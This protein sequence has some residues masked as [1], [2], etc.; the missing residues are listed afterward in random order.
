MR[1]LIELP[2][3]LGDSVMATPAIENIV[4][5]YNNPN[6]TL[7]GSAVSLEVLKNHPKVIKTIVMDKKYFPLLKT[8]RSLGKF[9]AFFSFRG[10]LRSTIFKIFITSINKFQ[11]NKNIYDNCHQV[12][13]YNNFINSSLRVLS[14][15]GELIIRLNSEINM[16]INFIQSKKPILGLNPGA[17]Y[18][19]AKRWNSKKFA[20]VASELSNKFDIL[21]FGGANELDITKEIELNLINNGVTNYKNLGGKTSVGELMDCISKLS[22]LITGDSGPMHIAAGFHIPTIS[23]FGPT[24]DKETSQWMNKKS[25]IIKKNL[26]CQPCMKR[27]CPLYHHNCM[28][29][30]EAEEVIKAA[31]SL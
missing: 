27:S 2:T 28:E 17:H 26:D 7:I 16:P 25:I 4:N 9:D 31:E 1:I 8:A 21:I 11:F 23:I 10:S 20:M 14:V 15:P 3:W 5:C 22:L 18:G 24:S 29:L 13:K 30:I 6:I 19:S 12:E